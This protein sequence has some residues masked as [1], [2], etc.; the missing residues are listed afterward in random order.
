MV[1]LAFI[2]VLDGIMN[3]NMAIPA[4]RMM[5]ASV[6]EENR[7][8]HAPLSAFVEMTVSSGSATPRAGIAHSAGMLLKFTIH[9]PASRATSLVSGLDGPV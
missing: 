1:R 2:A 7:N 5:H 8:A 9:A 3:G 4:V 6:S